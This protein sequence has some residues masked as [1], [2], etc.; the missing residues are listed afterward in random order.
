MRRP[1][2]ERPGRARVLLTVGGAAVAGVAVGAATMVALQDAG[3]DPPAGTTP[4]AATASTTATTPGAHATAGTAAAPAAGDPAASPAPP[5]ERDPRVAPALLLAWSPDGLDPGLAAAAAA[6]PAVGLPS[7]VRGGVVDLVASRD[8]SGAPVDSLEPGWAIPL[9]TVAFDPA[10]HADL[11]SLADREAV[12]ALAPRQAL[13][14]ATSA[15]LRRLGPGD[16]IDLAAGGSVTVANVVS[17]AAVGGAELAVDVVTGE[18]L[19]LRTDRYLIARYEGDRAAVEERLRG[20]LT[21]DASVRFRGPGETPFLRNGD[22]VLPQSHIKDRFGEFAYRPG[23]GDEFAQDPAW[24][25]ANLVTVDL[26]IIGTARCHRGIVD[27]LAG[28]LEEVVSA[29]LAE[30]IDPDGFAGCWNARTTRAGTSISRHAWGVAV[31]LNFGD[32]PTGLS[33]VQD[34]RLLAIFSRWGFTDGSGWLV[35]DAGHFEY[36]APPGA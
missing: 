4:A 32:N 10:L 17:D 34:E 6:D 11:V 2:T 22:A 29:H 16:V 26:P 20:A 25:A 18:A 14:G 8:V 7:T 9:D 28:A 21:E 13:L 19:G 5:R 12:A 27:A 35:P 3:H 1:G 24:Q 15:R 31:D 30:L 23:A 36:V 33:S